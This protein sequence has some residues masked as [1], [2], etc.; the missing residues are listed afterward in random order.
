MHIIIFITF[1]L[2]YTTSGCC[3]KVQ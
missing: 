2:F 1:T 3:F